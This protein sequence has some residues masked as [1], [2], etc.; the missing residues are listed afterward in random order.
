M[1]ARNTVRTLEVN[2]RHFD[3]SKAV[4]YIS[5]SKY[6]IIFKKGLLFFPRAQRVLSY[7]IYKQMQYRF[8]VNFGT[9]SIFMAI[10]T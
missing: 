8:A 5:P 6:E 10:I 4:V 1:V 9:L 2:V 3:L 7:L